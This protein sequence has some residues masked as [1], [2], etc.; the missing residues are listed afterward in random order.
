MALSP[1]LTR[2]R[3]E[4]LIGN[5]FTTAPFRG[6]SVAVDYPIRRGFKARETSAAPDG[7]QEQLALFVGRGRNIA[8]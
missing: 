3:K 2:A 8:I 6:P 1:A 5:T 4:G 7:H